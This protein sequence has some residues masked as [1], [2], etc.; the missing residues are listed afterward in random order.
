MTYP[1]QRFHHGS[2]PLW[3]TS[4]KGRGTQGYQS[5]KSLMQQAKPPLSTELPHPYY[6]YYLNIEV[7]E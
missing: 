1:Q 5:C 7:I 3:R 2:Y 4:E 6:Y